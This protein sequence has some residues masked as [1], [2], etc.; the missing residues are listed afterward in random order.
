VLQKASEDVA[1]CLRR[2]AE[3]ENRAEGTKDLNTRAEY[4]RIAETWRTLARNADLQ[5]CDEQ[6]ALFWR[7]SE[8]TAASIDAN[9]SNAT[10]QQGCIS[11]TNVRPFRKTDTPSEEP[12]K[13]LLLCPN[14]NV[15]MSLFGIE[16]ESDARD[17]YT[18]ECR[19]CDGLEVRGVRVR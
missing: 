6:Q 5:G 2:A 18:F 1:E 7:R 12:I 10:N 3:A 19:A 14:C 13:A 15:E 16:A 9:R 11:M 4:L 8:P 17:L